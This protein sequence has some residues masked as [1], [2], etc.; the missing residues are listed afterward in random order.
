WKAAK[1]ELLEEEEEPES[2]LE[3]LERKRQR[4]IEEWRAKQIAS[5]EAKDNAN[6]Q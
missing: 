1:E 2:V 3:A 6:F 4:E 5:G